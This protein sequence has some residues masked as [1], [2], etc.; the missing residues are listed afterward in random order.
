MSQQGIINPGNTKKLAWDFFVMFCVLSDAVVLPFQL[1]F[2]NQ[3]GPDTFDNFWFFLTTSVFSID[4]I[5][6]F[7]TALDKA[8]FELSYS[9]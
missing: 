3:S 7:N 1:A 8:G 4:I 2:K 9:E 5:L 6:S